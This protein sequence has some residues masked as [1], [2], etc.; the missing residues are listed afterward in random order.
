MPPAC[1]SLV[2][3]TAAQAIG[4]AVLDLGDL[5]RGD[6]VFFPGHVGIMTGPE[7]LLH[8]NAFH[9][10]VTEEPLADVV[11]RGAQVTGVRRLV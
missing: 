8:A 1:P 7:R 9:M 4:E 5:R 3:A 2:T 6:I 11:A 10:M